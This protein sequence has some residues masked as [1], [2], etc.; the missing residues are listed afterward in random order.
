MTPPWVTI[1]HRA[2]SEDCYIV[3]STIADWAWPFVLMGI[4]PPSERNGGWVNP[5]C[6]TVV[7]EQT[8]ERTA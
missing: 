7:L 1:E 4:E 5:G 8:Q 6:L 2:V 3:V